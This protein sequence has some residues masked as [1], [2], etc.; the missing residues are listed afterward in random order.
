MEHSGHGV[1]IVVREYGEK[2][3]TFSENMITVTIPFEKTGRETGEEKLTDKEMIVYNIMTNNPYVKR[4]DIISESG[5]SKNTVDKI[6]K[7][8]NVKSF[9]KGR[10]ADKGGKWKL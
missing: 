9:I 4:K 3:Y 5:Y 6:I 1:P 8:L 10:T 2:A 7:Q